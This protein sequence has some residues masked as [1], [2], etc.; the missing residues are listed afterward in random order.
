MAE[1]EGN[2][3][4]DAP[5]LSQEEYRAKQDEIKRRQEYRQ[6]RDA[7][8]NNMKERLSSLSLEE[9]EQRLAE[10]RSQINDIEEKRSEYQEGPFLDEQIFSALIAERKSNQTE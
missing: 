8:I 6:E 1:F 7:F 3:R 9:M 4:D 5:H 2:E 10:A